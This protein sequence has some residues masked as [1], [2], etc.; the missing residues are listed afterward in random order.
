MLNDTDFHILN[1][2]ATTR[3]A[4][5]KQLAESLDFSSARIRKPINRL[6]ADQRIEQIA[7]AHFGRRGRPSPVYQLTARGLSG[8]G[9]G[10][11]PLP[12][13]RKPEHRR[14]ESEKKSERASPSIQA[15]TV[16]K[17]LLRAHYYAMHHQ[18]LYCFKRFYEQVDCFEHAGEPW[19]WQ[20]PIPASL[21]TR[22][23][24][25][26]GEEGPRPVGALVGERTSP[27]GTVVDVVLPVTNVYEAVRLLADD[28]KRFSW[29]QKTDSYRFTVIYSEALL[30]I[31]D[32]L[33][34]SRPDFTHP[35]KDE[36]RTFA[37]WQATL[38]YLYTPEVIGIRR[39]IESTLASKTKARHAEIEKAQQQPEHNNASLD[40]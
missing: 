8:T 26:L 14:R 34:T 1:F 10:I 33:S 5:A 25:L 24:R 40:A 21:R 15:G 20:G 17:A 19:P 31:M 16:L 37:E 32:A 39:W 23:D 29:T 3:A 13:H 22:S 9:L 11:A 12:G 4:A 27:Q 35:L 30:P 18:E 7:S 2:L 36:S 38:K 28:G 6:L